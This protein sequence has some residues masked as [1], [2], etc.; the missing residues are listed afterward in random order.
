MSYEDLPL[1]P[2][3]EAGGGTPGATREPGRHPPA[4]PLGR[5]PS[6]SAP[7]PPPPARIPAARPRWRAARF[8]E[9][10]GAGLVDCVAL[11]GATVI[12]VLGSVLAGAR[13]AGDRWAPLALFLLAFSFVYTVVPLAFWGQTPGMAVLGLVARRPGQAPLSFRQAAARWLAGWATVLLAGLPALLALS[14]A[15]L[16]DRLTGSATLR[17]LP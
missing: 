17:R 6:V 2:E 8:G 10:V 16:A 5:P 9:R 14:G 12:V 15:S 3:A 13:L 4:P 11:A 1:F 7:S